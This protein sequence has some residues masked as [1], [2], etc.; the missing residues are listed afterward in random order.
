[1]GMT[2]AF[3]EAGHLVP[4]CMGAFLQ[5]PDSRTQ[6]PLVVVVVADARVLG[7]LAVVR[8]VS[9]AAAMVERLAAPHP[10]EVVVV[11]VAG[12]VFSFRGPTFL[13]LAAA[14]V[15]EEPLRVRTN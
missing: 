5:P 1:M 11:V 3:L 13:S 2:A 8:E 6:C 7:V 14:P 15:V 10:R 9:M 4:L 12:V